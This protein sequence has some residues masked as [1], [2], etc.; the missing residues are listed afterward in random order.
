MHLAQHSQKSCTE[1][2]FS[3]ELAYVTLLKCLVYEHS[4]PW[5]ARMRESLGIGGFKPPDAHSCS[6]SS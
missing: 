6:S 5:W 4:T 2:A 1:V 3:T